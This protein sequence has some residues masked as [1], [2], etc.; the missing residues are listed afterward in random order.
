MGK[1]K[2]DCIFVI[3]SIAAAQPAGATLVDIPASDPLG[4]SLQLAAGDY[5]V[6]YAGLAGGGAYDAWN[7]WGENAGCDS[8]GSRCAHGYLVQFSLDFGH[9]NGNFD[10]QDGFIYY[11]AGQ[12]GNFATAAQALANASAKPLYRA[13]LP[14]P[15]ASS[16]FS[17]VDGV[18]TFSLKASQQ[19][20]FYLFDAYYGDNTGGMSL[21]LTPIPEPASGWLFGGALAG[22]RRRSSS[23]WGKSAWTR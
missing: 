5:A 20:N 3:L 12:N 4:A 13:P 1:K 9:G 6:R 16:S 10:R 19:V 17:E 11:P 7:A 18:L 14:Y 22:L 23:H 2:L 21:N 8:S 15:S